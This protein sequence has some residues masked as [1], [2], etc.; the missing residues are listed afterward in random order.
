MKK[1]LIILS[2]I[3]VGL[4]IWAQTDEIS[5]QAVI[6]DP[7]A[8]EIPGV[9]ATGNILP[10]AKIAIR[11]TIYD[12]T[13]KI[14][15]QEEQQAETDR[16]GM[17]NLMIGSIN[18]EDFTRISWDGTEKELKVEIDFSASGSDYL[19]LS[20]QKLSFL[21]YAYHRNITATGTLKVDGNTNLNSELAVAGITN[22]NS[23]LNVK[24]KAN[25][26]S[27]LTVGDSTY[28]KSNLRVDKSA[29]INDSLTVSKSPSLFDGTITVEDTATFNGPAQFNAPVQF[30]EI[31][32]NGPSHLNGPVTVKADMDTIGGESEIS[33][34][35]LIVQGSSQGISVKVNGSRDGTNNYVSFW[36]NQTG[37]MW[38]RIE[39]Q[40]MTDVKADP[41]YKYDKKSLDNNVTIA[42]VDFAVASAEAV[43][44][45]VQLVAASSSSTACAGLG[46]CVTA[47]IPSFIVSDGANLVLAIANAASAGKNLDM[48]LSDRKAYDD[49][50]SDNIGVTYQSGAGDYAEWLPRENP[51]DIFKPG[52]VVGVK[53][54]KI[55]KSTSGVEKIMVISSN[56][57]V[58]GNMPQKNHE[59]EYE[60]VAFMGQVP[61]KIIGDV[62]AG[63]FILPS[64]LG[65]GFGVAKHPKDMQPYDY[66]KI[67]GVA[68]AGAKGKD[69]HFV[70]VAV[71]INTNNMA[72]IIQKQQEKLNALQAQINQ[73]NTILSR[74][75]PG[76]E[77]AL[78]KSDLN[79]DTTTYQ[80]VVDKQIN[81]TKPKLN[82]N[83]GIVQTSV[84]SNMKVPSNADIV[85]YKPTKDQLMASIDLAKKVYLES[86]KKL[87][88]SPF[89]KKME[90]EPAYK[91]EILKYMD[92]KI[93][94]AIKEQSQINKTVPANTKP[95]KAR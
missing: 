67:I 82:V 88:D 46:A 42:S 80:Q 37:Q 53:N 16:Y 85:Y 68:W 86:G 51:K 4:P 71:G 77:D 58:L 30:V 94:K 24:S 47:P 33:A 12:S 93:T 21:P 22:L 55:T 7:N 56:P 90:N 84:V 57:I 31:A 59:K 70:N 40:T 23:S 52:D 20:R 18:H 78:D 45:G 75:V 61:V 36:D 39:G 73:T 50:I 35:P 89:W 25:L 32:V 26:E 76:F 6:I 91:T 38:G 64:I 29:L 62:E 34:Y 54:G 92:E 8:K 66:G 10:N 79:V 5:Y 83:N 15:F 19:E 87:E 44:A 65:S 74:L 28:L 13:N 2:L 1:L 49:F 63:D 41:E 69:V 60:K 95:F 11:F 3:L 14:E 81:Q 48:V 17:I 72:G 9:D 27:T 43:Q